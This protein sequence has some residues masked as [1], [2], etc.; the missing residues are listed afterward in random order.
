MHVLTPSVTTTLAMLALAALP[1]MGAPLQF[2]KQRIGTGTYEA[3]AILDVNN[4]GVLDIVSGE[5]WHPGPTFAASHKIGTILEQSTYY[6]DFSNYPMDVN[7]DGYLDIVT[8]GWFGKKVQWRENPQGQPVEWPVHDID[9]VG[10]VERGCFWDL[11]GDGHVELVPNLPNDGV[12]AFKLERDASGK[13]TGTF[14]R[15]DLYAEKQGHG[16]GF[17]DINGDG[18]GDLILHNGW[19]EAPENTFEGT[20]TL[21]PEF[22]L[23]ESSVPIL[24][25]DVNGDGKNDLIVGQG[26]DYGLA[27]Y[28]QGESD[29]KRTW[30]RHDIETKRSQFHDMD[31]ADLDRDGI[32]ELITGKRYHAHNGSD[33]GAAE[34]VSLTYYVIAGGTFERHD[35]DYGPP[36]TSSGTGIYFWVADID[37]NG[38]NDILAPGKEGVYL[39]KNQGT[40]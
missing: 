29:G 6:D 12:V 40:P 8:G 9:T 39:F 24:V 28:A 19:L 22:D 17:G 25:Y 26:H 5:Y 34:P 7:G 33:P 38:W 32:P 4:D 1:A 27:W 3:G 16:L 15:Y 21:H 30:T 18:R 14:K 35:I 10:N 31:L 13:G 23:G 11:D 20:W 36:E 37:G 2:E